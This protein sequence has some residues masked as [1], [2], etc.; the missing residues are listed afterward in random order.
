MVI[1]NCKIIYISYSQWAKPCLFLYE[2]LVYL[3]LFYIIEYLH[4]P[5]VQLFGKF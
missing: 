5:M 4:L 2:K 1:K 3:A